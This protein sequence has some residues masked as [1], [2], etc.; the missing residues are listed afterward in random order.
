LPSEEASQPVSRATL[1]FE[2]WARL[3]LWVA[4]GRPLPIE[5]TPKCNCQEK[6][7]APGSADHAYFL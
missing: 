3:I 2:N 7:Y 1:P 5:E 6:R 4:A